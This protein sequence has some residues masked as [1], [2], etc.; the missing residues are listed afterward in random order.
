MQNKLLHKWQP[1]K[2]NQPKFQKKKKNLSPDCPIQNTFSN[3][4]LCFRLDNP[5]FFNKKHTLEF[6]NVF[7]IEKKN[8][9]EY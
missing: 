4:E 2:K 7:Q 6:N 5:K 1:F 3:Q 9:L 8:I